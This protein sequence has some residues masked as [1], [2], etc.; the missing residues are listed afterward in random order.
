MNM[1]REQ[2][3]DRHLEAAGRLASALHDLDPRLELWKASD[4]LPGP[5]HGAKPG[6]WHVVRRNDPPTPD[7]YMV[8]TDRGL[9][10]M[11]GGFREPDS[12]VIELLRQGDMHRRGYA[13][14]SDDYDVVEAAAQ[15]ERDRQTEQRGDEVRSDFAAA[16]R[17]AG[18]GGLEKRLWGKG[19]VKLDDAG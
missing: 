5:I 12:G 19:A 15:K 9:G 10:V 3:V 1:R 17:V 16:K 2:A 14:P 4:R 7:S 8:I 13:L 6:F 18:D 11:D